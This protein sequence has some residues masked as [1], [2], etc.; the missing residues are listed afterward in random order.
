MQG[1]TPKYSSIE[2]QHCTALI[3][4]SVCFIQSS[5][6]SP[7]LAI[8]TSAGS[9]TPLVA[10][11]FLISASLLARR[12][13][14][15]SFRD[16]AEDFRKVHVSVEMPVASSNLLAVAHRVKSGRAR[17]DAADA[18][19]AHAIDDATNCGKPGEVLS[20]IARIRAYGVQ[21]R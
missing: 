7:S 9:G 15:P 21:A 4:T 12:N 2:V 16:P 14:R 10:T 1:T 6:T 20:K 13:R 11:Y 18:Q 19:I 17:A 5:I 3:M 8:F